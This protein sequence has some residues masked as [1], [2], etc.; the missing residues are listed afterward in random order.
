LGQTKEGM[1]KIDVTTQTRDILK[2]TKCDIGK[3]CKTYD[4]LLQTLVTGHK[5]RKALEKKVRQLEQDI[6]ALREAQQTVTTSTPTHPLDARSIPQQATTPTSAVS[7]ASA[8]IPEPKHPC[9]FHSFG[10]TPNDVNCMKDFN[11]KG[12]VHHLTQQMC[13]QCWNQKKQELGEYVTCGAKQIVN[14]KGLQLYCT[15][16]EC[17]YQTEWHRIELCKNAKCHFLIQNSKQGI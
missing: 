6:K 12:V 17:P 4:D 5:V 10:K 16:A 7:T 3:D 14:G 1:T 15:L 2:E 8:K 11:K 9:E 13:D